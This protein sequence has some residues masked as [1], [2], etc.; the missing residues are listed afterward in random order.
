[1]TDKK[2]SRI[3]RLWIYIAS[4]VAVIAVVVVIAVLFLF[5]EP[6]HHNLAQEAYLMGDYDTALEEFNQAV[7]QDSNNADYLVG[8]G[9][10]H[11]NLGNFGA[12]LGDFNNAIL[13]D[14]GSSDTRPAFYGGYI[15]L[16]SENYD[17]AVE[18]FNIA[19]ERGESSA[20]V[21]G[22]RGL[23]FY[24]LGDYESAI[25]DAETAISLN[26]TTADYYKILGDSHYEL[27][28]ND[29]ALSAYNSYIELIITPD[30][31]V[32]SNISV[33]NAQE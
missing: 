1:M 12:A 18:S 20:E 6:A 3:P 2:L 30:P 13:L 27:G 4:L 31:D 15:M 14:P 8:R 22:N 11:M 5:Q 32:M 26:N 16:I 24:H 10:T 9:L 25:I 29:L 21:Y 19:I 28:N 23:A 33:I 7:A 17:F